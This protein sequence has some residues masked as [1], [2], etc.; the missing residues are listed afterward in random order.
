MENAGLAQLDGEGEAELGVQSNEV[1]FAFSFLE[2]IPM[3]INE[4]HRCLATCRELSK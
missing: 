2:E 1:P 4:L 3:V